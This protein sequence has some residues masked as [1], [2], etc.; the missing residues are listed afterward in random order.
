MWHPFWWD[1]LG[2]FAHMFKHVQFTSII[3]VQF[4]GRWMCC[5]LWLTKFNEKKWKLVLLERMWE[6][7]YSITKWKLQTEII[8]LRSIWI[9]HMTSETYMDK[10]W[11]YYNEKFLFRKRNASLQ[12]AGFKRSVSMILWHSALNSG[13]RKSSSTVRMPDWTAASRSWSSVTCRPAHSK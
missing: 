4:V 6:S 12:S 7:T 3:K 8:N 11:R 5:H 2:R 10:Q 1:Y 9:K 13:V